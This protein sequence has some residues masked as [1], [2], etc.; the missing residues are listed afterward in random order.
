MRRAH[1]KLCYS[2]ALILRVYPRQTHE[3]LFD[4]HVNAFR[5]LG[6]VPRRGIYDNMRT[7]VDKVGRG[8]ERKVNMR[9]SAMVS[10][11]LFE[12]EFCNPAAGWE[13][14]RIGKNVQDAR[15][16][17][18]RPTPS[19]PSQPGMVADV[20]REE[21]QDLAQLL[22]PFDGFVEHTKRVSPTCLI[23]LERNR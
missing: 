16:R 17:L 21:A 23:H 5:V 15:H 3:M 20:W 19:F 22:R 6:G 12:A 14:G 13:K 10:H 18:W 1:V 2:R 7:A 11:F 8:K 9:F 4:A